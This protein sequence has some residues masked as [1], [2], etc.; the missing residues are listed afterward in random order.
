MHRTFLGTPGIIK[1]K[2]SST[3]VHVEIRDTRIEPHIRWKP[4]ILRFCN[5]IPYTKPC[6]GE[7][8]EKAYKA[9]ICYLCSCELFTKRQAASKG[10]CLWISTK[11][12]LKSICYTRELVNQIKF[13]PIYESYTLGQ[14]HTNRTTIKSGLSYI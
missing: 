6:W 8:N 3:H 14:A 13:N 2:K 9:Q 12:S 4:P 10:Y 7:I 11:F 5:K 1:I